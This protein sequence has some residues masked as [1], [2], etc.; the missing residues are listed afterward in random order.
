MIQMIQILENAC[1]A[2]RPGGRLVY[3]TCSIEKE[4]DADVVQSFLSSHPDFTLEQDHLALPHIEH[5]DGAFA[6]LLRRA[7]T[8]QSS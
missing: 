3:S 7:D 2:V 8:R 6:A 4:E 5:A 1:A